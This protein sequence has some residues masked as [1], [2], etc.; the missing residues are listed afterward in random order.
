MAEIPH[1]PNHRQKSW[2]F[3]ATLFYIACFI[4]L[5]YSLKKSGIGPD[6]IK[7]RDMA[8]M[9]LATYRLTRLLV[10][11]AIFK[12]FRDFVK[13][14]ANYLVFYVIR[15][16]ITCPWCA[17]VWAA[18]IIIAIYYFVPFGQILIIL[19]A[20]SGVA[21]FIVILVNCFGLTTE[22]KQHRVKEL[23]EESDYS[24]QHHDH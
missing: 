3:L 12:L 11:D 22:E 20:I 1:K 17:G 18:I 6:D 10:F 21:S 2:N 15:E 13:S 14:R 4:A 9:T 5:G 8:L 24:S 23:R 16:I 7:F 19:F